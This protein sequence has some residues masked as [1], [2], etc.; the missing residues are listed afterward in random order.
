MS[1]YAVRSVLDGS[2]AKGSARLLLVI[3]AEHLNEKT[4]RCDPSLATLARES[5]ASLRTIPRLL[6]E[7]KVKGEIEIHKGGGRRHCNSYTIKAAENPDNAVTV[8][9]G[10]PDTRVTVSPSE[11]LTPVSLFIPE[12]VT[13]Q[14]RNS[15]THVTRTIRNQKDKSISADDSDFAA[16][17]SAYPRKVAKPAALKAWRSAKDRPP[18]ADLLA[19]LDRHK[20]SEQWQAARFIPHPATWINGQRWDDQLPTAEERKPPALRL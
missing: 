16:F 10:N 2:K 12:T 13:N 3:L 4:R 15:D 18:L 1:C 11:T 8:S 7:L 5:N 9:D 19:A 6:A 17:W 20:R 14:V